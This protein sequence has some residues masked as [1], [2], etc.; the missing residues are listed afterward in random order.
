MNAE[1]KNGHDINGG[2]GTNVD[3]FVATTKGWSP[4][5]SP[6]MQVLEPNMECL[7][8]EQYEG[9]NVDVGP[10]GLDIVPLLKDK[11]IFITGGTGF[12]A[13]GNNECGLI[14]LTTT[15]RDTHIVTSK[16]TYDH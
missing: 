7:H 14:V 15:K 9:R 4:N 2:G 12:L 6:M 1:L 16:N 3:S 13:K 11:A 8:G 10:P 5:G